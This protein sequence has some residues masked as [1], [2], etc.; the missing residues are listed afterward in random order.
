MKSIDSGL[1]DRL[2]L[3]TGPEAWRGVWSSVYGP[4]L[5]VAAVWGVA[6]FESVPEQIL[7]PVAGSFTAM[8][9]LIPLLAVLRRALYRIEFTFDSGSVSV[10]E[11]CFSS[12]TFRLDGEMQIMIWIPKFGDDGPSCLSAIFANKRRNFGLYLGM[13]QLRMVAERLSRHL[14]T[15][16]LECKDAWSILGQVKNQ[17]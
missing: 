13:S 16:V 10:K 9:L 1:P 3:R 7:W 15:P 2:V 8:C 4:G 5:I 6:Y 17:P 12:R 14:E 11:R